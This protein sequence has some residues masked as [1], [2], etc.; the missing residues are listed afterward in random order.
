MTSLF[1]LTLILIEVP[2]VPSRAPGTLYAPRTRIA[3]GR[4]S[5]RTASG[6]KSIAPRT[7]IAPGTRIA[8]GRRSPRTTPGPRRP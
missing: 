7:T 4:R 2:L 5:P 8:P 3:P 6:P 1:S